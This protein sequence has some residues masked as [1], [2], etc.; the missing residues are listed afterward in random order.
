M[1][2][3]DVLIFIVC[4]GMTVILSVLLLSPLW[5]YEQTLQEEFLVDCPDT[6]LCTRTPILAMAVLCLPILLF[7]GLWLLLQWNFT[8]YDD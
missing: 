1:I 2:L 8:R 7:F 5:D 6:A 4:F 3:K